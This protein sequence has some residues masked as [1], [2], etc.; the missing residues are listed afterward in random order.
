MSSRFPIIG[1]AAIGVALGGGLALAQQQQW[2]IH[3]MGSQIGMPAY[4]KGAAPLAEL[5]E[6]Q[7]VYVDKGSFKLNIGAGDATADHVA[8]MGAKEVAH[9]AIIF[10]SGGKLYLVDW[11]KGE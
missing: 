11:K 3:S 9:G 1:L 5:G 7:G 10:R 2:G 4:M 6:N 8:R